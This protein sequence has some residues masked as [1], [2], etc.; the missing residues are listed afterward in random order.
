MMFS[1]TRGGGLG[2]KI[3]IQKAYDIVDWDFIF[4]VLR[5]FGFSK[6][7]I[8][9][10]HQMLVFAKISVLLNGGPIGYFGVE[11]GLRQGGA[12][13]LMLF[14]LAEEVLC[15]GLNKLVEDK[16]LKPIKGP[17]GVITPAHSLFADDIFIFANASIR[18]VRH[19]NI[20]L[21]RYQE[22]SGQCINLVKSKLF[23]GSASPQR[24]RAIA[25]EL[26]IPLCTF[27]TRYLGVEIFKG[28]VKK[29]VVMP[30]MDRV[31]DRLAEWK[32]KMLSL[33]GRVELVRS[34]II[35]MPTHSIAV[36]WWPSSLISTLERWMRNFIWS[37]EID[38]MKKI[39]V[40][41][42]QCCKPREE[43]G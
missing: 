41:R 3:D 18:Y 36:Y 12:I 2:V 22:F 6:R 21:N 43:G 5:K 16:K 42:D 14:I 33:A 7:W 26:G 38:T 28:R 31:K 15:R 32:G 23:V 39:V 9:W 24:K 11:R 13:S 10:V 8:L 17:H 37:G 25:E 20:F 30:I 4:H 1:V 34:V 27:P 40:N 35:S 29:D 19:L